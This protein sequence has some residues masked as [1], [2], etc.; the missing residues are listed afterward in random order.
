MGAYWLPGTRGPRGVGGCG[1]ARCGITHH[2]NGGEPLWG[3]NSVLHYR[4]LI[5]GAV[6]PLLCLDMAVSVQH[7]GFYDTT[8]QV[9]VIKYLDH[10]ENPKW[11]I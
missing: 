8:Y 7:M 10:L 4:Y 6:N 3:Q 11:I 9:L 2:I 5:S 1:T